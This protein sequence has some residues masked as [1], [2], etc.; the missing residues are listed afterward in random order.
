MNLLT[1][2][3][4]LSFLKIWDTF[5][6]IHLIVLYCFYSHVCCF[7]LQPDSTATER[8]VARLAMHPLLKKKIDVLKGMYY[9]TVN[10]Y[11]NEFMCM[12]LNK[13]LFIYFFGVFF[14]CFEDLL[15]I[16]PSNI[17]KR[18]RMPESMEVI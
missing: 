11:L 9:V 10:M 18:G 13:W 3:C 1:N 6:F 4:F 14:V 17:F 2:S 8:A 5:S 15:Q 12:I 16:S 7:H